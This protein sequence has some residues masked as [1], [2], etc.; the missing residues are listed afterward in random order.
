[1]CVLFHRM[2]GSKL[3]GRVDNVYIKF[4]IEFSYMVIP[5][6]LV[7][8]LT[9]FTIPI[10]AFMLL[11]SLFVW[12]TN[13]QGKIDK[14]TE[15][16]IVAALSGSRKSFLDEYRAFMMMMTCVA[17]LAVDF[18]FFPR[19]FAKTESFGISLMD[20]GV[21]GVVLA[22][23]IVSRLARSQSSDSSKKS[24]KLV[25]PPARFYYVFGAIKGSFPLF[26]LGLVRILLT[27]SVNYQEHVSEYGTHWN[28]FFTLMAVGLISSILPISLDTCATFGFVIFY[29]I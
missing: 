17:I 9:E 16:R 15:T 14:Q 24:N 29:G 3:T 27:K 19:R 7:M 11:S 5:A 26:I 4:M 23:A 25:K 18:Q 10:Y 22:G 8:T 21:G 2:V 12:Y 13:T 6:I 28:F 1:M 20:M